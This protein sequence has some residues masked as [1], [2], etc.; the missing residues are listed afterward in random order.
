ML[1]AILCCAGISLLGVVSLQSAKPQ[2]PST[3]APAAVSDYRST[4]NRYCV[5]CHNEKL[6]TS[7]LTLEKIDIENA[8]AGAE[9]WE[10]VIRKLRGNAMPPPGLPQ[11]PKAFYES[12]PAYLEI[13]IDRAAFAKLNPGRPAIHRL[14]RVEYA[15]AVHDF[16]GVDIDG[17]AL[18]P[19][20]DSGYGFD[21]IGD[22]LSVSPTLLERY[23]TAARTISRLAVG[24][25][26]VR[27]VD[28][29]YTVA[30]GLIQSDRMSEELP[31]RSR[32]GM[33]VRHDFPAD[34][35]Y[36]IKVRLQ[37]DGD[38]V[39]GDGGAIRGVGLKRQL[40]VRLDKAR[41]KLFAVG[42]EHFGASGD[43]SGED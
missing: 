39:N 9:V 20:D 13:A 3:P 16:L 4:L 23:L 19:A 36:I 32:G 40:D 11:P 8:P 33:A 14:N 29:T 25:P 6:K 43:D 21:N 1:R 27:P 12:F 26:A 28:E 42:G 2:K 22:V 17:E 15:N 34:G 30:K 38:P 18:L 5:T 24:D 10:K 41:L 31:L 35:E 37:R 7:G